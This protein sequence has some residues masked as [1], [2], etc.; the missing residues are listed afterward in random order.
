MSGA[1]QIEISLARLEKGGA[2]P[3]VTNRRAAR[4][5]R[6]AIAWRQE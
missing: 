2:L 5:P 4:I 1:D 6:A 3:S